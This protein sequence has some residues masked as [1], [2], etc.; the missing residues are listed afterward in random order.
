MIPKQIPSIAG[1]KATQDDAR[2]YAAERMKNLRVDSIQH[3]IEHAYMQGAI[4]AFSIG[5]KVAYAEKDK[6]WQDTVNYYK[7]LLDTMGEE[8]YSCALRRGK[9]T[10][11]D[12]H[13]DIVAGITVEI[14]EFQE[15][16][17]APS[18]HL[19]HYSQRQEELADIL[20]CCLTELHRT[21]VGITSLLKAKIE[22]NKTR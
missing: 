10:P 13:E 8:A 9:I 6:D 20:I 3:A 2:L 5:Y 11:A 18:E 15:A 4:R 16:T 7:K 12:T 17:D 14:R 1:D 21:K 22:F 19:P